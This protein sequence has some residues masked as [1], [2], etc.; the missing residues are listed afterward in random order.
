MGKKEEE[1]D[2]ATRVERKG[3]MNS[4]TRG[5]RRCF[6]AEG[7]F[8]VLV[9]FCFEEAFQTQMRAQFDAENQ[10]LFV[11]STVRQMTA[12]SMTVYFL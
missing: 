4:R 12:S 10:I 6:R 7:I 5:N 8:I 9:Y 11:L 3:K 2:K 1:A